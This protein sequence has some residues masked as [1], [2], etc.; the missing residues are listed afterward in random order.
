MVLKGKSFQVSYS[1]QRY[2]LLS[3]LLLLKC[4]RKD[5]KIQK[6]YSD[7]STVKGDNETAQNVRKNKRNSCCER[8]EF[9]VSI[10][11][12]TG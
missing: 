7:P 4:F 5:Y 11:E 6:T 1:M 2:W 8:K 3:S 10:Q 9:P 12:S